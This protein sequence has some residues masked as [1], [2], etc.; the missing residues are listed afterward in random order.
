MTIRGLQNTRVRPMG[1]GGASFLIWTLTDLLWE[2]FGPKEK[3]N[4]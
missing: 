2:I 3:A 4:P 1:R